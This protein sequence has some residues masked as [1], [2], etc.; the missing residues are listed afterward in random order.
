MADAYQR[1]PYVEP[2]WRLG[3]LMRQRGARTAA[4]IL[5]SGDRS[6]QLWSNLGNIIAN[7]TTG[8]AQERAQAPYRQMQLEN[9]QLENQARKA[10]AAGSQASQQIQGEALR[11]D[12]ETGVWSYDRNY[13]ANAFK[14]AGIAD[15]LPSVL[16]GLD[17]FDASA[18]SVQAAKRDGLAGLAYGVTQLGNT[19]EAFNQAIELA[20]KNGF[21][22]RAEVGPMLQQVGDDPRRIAQVVRAIASSSPTFAAKL[23]PKEPKLHNVP[24]G[25]TVL[26]V[27]NPQA[28]PVFTAPARPDAP[29]AVGSFEDFV[30]TKYG[31]RPTPDQIAEGRKI[32]QQADDRPR[33]PAQLTPNAETLMINRWVNQWTAASKPVRELERQVNIMDEA[34]KAARSGDLAQ[35]GQA[36]LVTFQKILDP[37]S[38]VRESE[39]DRS[40]EGQ[41]LMQRAQ[42]ALER[43]TQGGPGVPIGELEKYAALARQIAQAQGGSR[44]Q[45]QRERIGRNADRYNIPRDLIFE[46]QPS[47]APAV[48]ATPTG[49]G[50]VTVQTPDG[51]SFTFPNQAQADQFKR[52]AGIP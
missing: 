13:L 18:R 34:L 42:G 9:T 35:G 27:N 26:D 14:Q 17:A 28:G 25:A 7:T 48:V 43:L 41:S 31:P 2:Q 50:P 19:P 1:R 24:A 6:A 23:G 22:T 47:A 12:P 40:R 3:D 38:V 15:R 36:I 5:E 11:Q 39:F 45:A 10:E 33:G 51:Q 21:I 29:P 32:Y 44:L 16:E 20:V 8:I 4:A 49:A 52:R 46:D 30:T 37:T